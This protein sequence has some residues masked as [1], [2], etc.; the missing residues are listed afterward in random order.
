[1]KFTLYGQAIAV[2]RRTA[3]PSTRNKLAEATGCIAYHDGQIVAD[4]FDVYPDGRRAWRHR[5]SGAPITTGVQD[6]QHGFDA[7]VI[8]D[9]GSALTRAEY[10][11]LLALR[12][13]HGVQLLAAGSRQ[14]GRPRPAST[15]PIRH[16]P[17]IP[18][19]SRYHPRPNLPAQGWL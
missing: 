1:M 17:Q 13:E 16:S 8:D 14:T 3:P 15:G 6:P 5:P 10:D 2:D 4:Y 9:T 19:E 11:D 18:G 12:S 7:V